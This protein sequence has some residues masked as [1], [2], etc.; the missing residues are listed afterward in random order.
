MLTDI[1]ILQNWQGLSVGQITQVLTQDV[2]QLIDKGIAKKVETKQ[3]IKTES[4]KS[5]GK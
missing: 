3:T 4:K 5:V 2:E 1:I